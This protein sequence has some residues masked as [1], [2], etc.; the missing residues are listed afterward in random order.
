M[1][2]YK[3]RDLAIKK[4]GLEEVERI[5]AEVREEITGTACDTD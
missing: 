3:A 2:V 4:L 1:K 5:T